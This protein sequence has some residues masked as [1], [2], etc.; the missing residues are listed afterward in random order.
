[1]SYASKCISEKS[2]C[3]TTDYFR[4]YM[5]KI[6]LLRLQTLELLGTEKGDEIL[7]LQGRNMA[8]KEVISAWDTLLDEI[9]KRQ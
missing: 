6:N 7:R 5:H 2:T 8:F 4:E 1:M 3:E 9:K